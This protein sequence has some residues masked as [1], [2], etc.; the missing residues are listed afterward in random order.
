MNGTPAQHAFLML[1]QFTARTPTAELLRI[2]DNA[3]ALPIVDALALLAGQVGGATI[4]DTISGVLRAVAKHRQA[5]V[6][7][8][9]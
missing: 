1:S 8:N 9:G 3:D 4:V 7:E 2:A 5:S 6:G